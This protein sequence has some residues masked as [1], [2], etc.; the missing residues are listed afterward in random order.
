MHLC[1]QGSSLC[2]LMLLGAARKSK[3]RNQSAASLKSADDTSN[4]NQTIDPMQINPL[5]FGTPFSGQKWTTAQILFPRLAR[6]TKPCFAQSTASFT[7]KQRKVS[8]PAPRLK[9][10]LIHSS[11]FSKIKKPV[12][13]AYLF[14]QKFPNSFPPW[15]FPPLIVILAI[16]HLSRIPNYRIL[17]VLL[18][19]NHAIWIL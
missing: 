19:K 9:I 2:D 14:L 1:A 6:T 13:E 18:C 8:Q 5:L 17:L 16:S 12:S 7:R 11:S 4:L 10:L 15:I 3:N